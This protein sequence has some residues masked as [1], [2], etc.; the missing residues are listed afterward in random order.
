MTLTDR[1]NVQPQE[2]AT[3]AELRSSVQFE[4]GEVPIR[5]ALRHGGALSTTLRYE[6]IG[7]ANGPLLIIAG[8][9]SAG[10]HVLASPNFPNPD[11]GNRKA[12]RSRQTAI[13]FSRSTGSAPTEQSTSRSTQLT[14][15]M[16]LQRSWTS[17]ASRVQPSSAHPMAEWSACTSPHATQPG[18]ARFLRSAPLLNPIHS[19]AHAGRS[20]AKRCRLEKVPVSRTPESRS[21]EPWQCSPIERPRN[22]PRDSRMSRPLNTDASAWAPMITSL[23][24]AHG[25]ADA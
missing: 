9:I 12:V 19:R 16:R 6:L 5:L 23:L 14:R 21:P 20:N 1:T 2:P 25:T 24:T 22:S 11:G 17:S 10:R 8:G 18:S 15:P 3:D 4:R 7:N 13:A